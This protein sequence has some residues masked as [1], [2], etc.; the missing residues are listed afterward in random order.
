MKINK[1]NYE[2]YILDYLEDSLSESEREAVELFV[3]THPE[4]DINLSEELPE[5]I[6]VKESFD[7][8]HLKRAIEWDEAEVSNL[9]I[10]LLESEIDKADVEPLLLGKIKDWQKS[11]PLK[12]NSLEDLLRKTYIQPNVQEEQSLKAGLLKLPLD[13]ADYKLVA[14]LEGDLSSKESKLLAKEVGS[15]PALQRSVELYRKTVL[16]PESMELPAVFKKELKRKEIKVIPFWL[17][18][19]VSAAAVVL[20]GFFA[21]NSFDPSQEIKT[22]GF[23]PRTGSGLANQSEVSSFEEEES[24]N[25]KI[26]ESVKDEGDVFAYVSTDHQ[27]VK[28]AN[29]DISHSPKLEIMNA[30]YLGELAS[31]FN[32]EDISLAGDVVIEDLSGLAIYK[33]IDVHDVIEEDAYAEVEESISPFSFVR[34]VVL[35]KAKQEDEEALA[36]ALVNSTAKKLSDDQD[37]FIVYQKA[38]EGGEGFKLKIG[39]FS[40]ETTR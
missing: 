40:L 4:L 38:D 12:F 22:A 20:L 26:V 27:G 24:L 1:N 29:S 5:L 6:P 11:Y 7:L 37:E 36:L 8:S 28:N 32:Y 39:K 31:S 30:N 35:K 13:H 17:Y 33:S 18:G 25:L 19:S 23:T 16:A 15:D 34:N 14:S 21:L 10:E 3:A 2:A 9:I